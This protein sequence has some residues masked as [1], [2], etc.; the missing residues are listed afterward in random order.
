MRI[1]L[2]NLEPQ[3]VNSAM[4]RVSS[5]HKKRGDQVEMYSPFFHSEYD[6]IYVFSLFKFT[7]KEG[8]DDSVMVCGGT[9]FGLD[10]R[11]PPE[12]EQE[13]YDWSLYPGCDFSIIWFSVGCIRSCPFCVVRQKEGRIRPVKPKNLNPKGQY[14]KVMDNN[15]FANPEWTDAIKQLK[16]WKQSVDFQG[17][18]VR[19]ITEEQA[20]ALNS[21]KHKKC[22]KIAWDNPKDD[23]LPKIKE[24]T[25]F[26]KPYKL[27]CYVLIGYWSTPEED[28]YRVEELRKLKV[29]PFV[30]P[31]NKSDLYQK[32]FARWVNHKAI[33]KTVAWRD[34][35][36]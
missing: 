36:V 9:G 34:Y 26:I 21:L 22:I 18:D 29:M 1:A 2:W 16:E 10:N 4:M 3:I 6:K 20:I 12:I 25:K 14:I 23:L 17:V 31:F 28:L 11:L 35:N 33:F 15:F 30:M 8:V 27:M 7:P 5:Y 24:L 32:K 13:E 19:I